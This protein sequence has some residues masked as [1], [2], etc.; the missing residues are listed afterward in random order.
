MARTARKRVKKEEEEKIVVKQTEQ[1]PKLKGRGRPKKV[2]KI[3]DSDAEEW[4]DCIS[5]NE[6]TTASQSSKTRSPISA[7][8]TI[9]LTSASKTKPLN[10]TSKTTSL[11]SAAK[12]STSAANTTSLTSVGKRRRNSNKVKTESK[13][14]SQKSVTFFS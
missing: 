13:I 5:D 6:L 14:F 10:S 2:S 12:A 7:L 11:T 1:K 3:N 4:F 9:S 8:K